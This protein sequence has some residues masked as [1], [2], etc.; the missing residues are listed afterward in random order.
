MFSKV[1]KNKRISLISLTSLLLV[2]FC[3]IP[4]GKA[5]LLRAEASQ[6]AGM[7]H[8]AAA[9]MKGHSCHNSSSSDFQIKE[10][11]L[12]S[13]IHCDSST[14]AIIQSVKSSFS[15]DHPASI[16]AEHLLS[17]NESLNTDQKWAALKP[18]GEVRPI[19]ILNSIFII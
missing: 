6:Q 3:L 9:E 1:Y 8:E 14:P 11:D 17:Y 10:W 4:C 18:P 16:R 19:H 2:S 15:I 13:C 5:G 7:R 12:N